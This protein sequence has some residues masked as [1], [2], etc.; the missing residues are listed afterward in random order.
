MPNETQKLGT[1]MQSKKHLPQ[2]KRKSTS[3]KGGPENASARDQGYLDVQL[4]GIGSQFDESLTAM[5]TH[6]QYPGQIKDN[7]E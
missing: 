6:E 7:N 4:V 3:P 5:G 1:T 2:K